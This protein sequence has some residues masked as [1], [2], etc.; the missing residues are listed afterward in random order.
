MKR[1]PP[2][3]RD[4]IAAIVAMHTPQGLAADACWLWQGFVA[5]NGYGRINTFRIAAHRAALILAGVDVPEHLDACHTCDVRAC[6][7]P[8]HLYAGSR[9]RNMLD[10]SERQRHNKPSGERNA[11]AKL[12]A[13]D[14]AAI[15]ERR[16]RGETIT[17]LA[18]EFAVHH[19]T[20][21]RI[22]NREWR[23]EVA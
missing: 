5:S 13:A 1:V 10:C 16:E 14:V 18:R 4:R 15:R 9:S 20:I 23:K 19:A 7:N 22:A 3:L 12:S 2:E 21:S 17:R 6:V 11:R 8:R